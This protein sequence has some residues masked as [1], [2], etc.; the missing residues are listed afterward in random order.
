MRADDFSAHTKTISLL[1]VFSISV[2]GQSTSH[3][4]TGIV[5]DASGSSVPKASVTLLSGTGKHVESAFSGLDGS[6]RLRAS[7]LTDGQ[8]EIQCKGF[9][10]FVLHLDLSLSPKPILAVLQVSDVYERVDVS[11][12][13][14]ADHV[15]T[16]PAE[17]RDA[18]VLD[19]NMLEQLPVFDQDYIGA[20]SNFLDQGAGGNMGTTIVVDGMEQKDAGVTPSAVQ[21]AKINNDP[22]SAE[23]S[24]PGR[25]RI[26]ITTKT[27]DPVYHGTANFIF[28]DYNLDARN[29]FATERPPEQRRIYEGVLTGPLPHVSRTFFLLSGDY[30]QDNLQSIVFAQLPSGLLRT[31]VPSPVRAKDIAARLSHDFSDKHTGVLQFTYE[32]RA[33]QNQ[34]AAGQPVNAGQNPNGGNS[35]QNQANGGYVLP[36]AGKN[37][38]G[39]E[40]HLKYSDHRVPRTRRQTVGVEL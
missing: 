12:S 35:G 18:T 7:T 13:A 33:R 10:P 31:N 26:E 30:Q 40:R 25:G 29:A 5:K 37:T 9:K 11:V 28:R 21:S 38:T 6:F 23:F 15:S 34:L 16:D 36:E 27:P 39:I 32:G 17:N 4:I 24:R 22:Y 2:A 14:D 1:A 20:V 8:L 3:V 19:N